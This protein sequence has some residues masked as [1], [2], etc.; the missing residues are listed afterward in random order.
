M[1]VCVS[2]CV[3]VGCAC[4]RACEMCVMCVLYDMCVM[5]DV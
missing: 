1:C 2:V 5:C 3:R 4:V